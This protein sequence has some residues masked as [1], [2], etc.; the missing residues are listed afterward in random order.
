MEFNVILVSISIAILIMYALAVSYHIDV[1]A[2]VSLSL[3]IVS[4]NIFFINVQLSYLENKMCIF[5][6]SII[7]RLILWLIKL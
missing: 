1:I 2:L 5:Q 6:T 3:L 7:V 4:N